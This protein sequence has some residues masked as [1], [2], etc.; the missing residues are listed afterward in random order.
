M[1]AGC[2]QQQILDASVPQPGRAPCCPFIS[3]CEEFREVS[4]CPSDTW[5][6]KKASW[7]QLP[8]R[9]LEPSEVSYN[10]ERCLEGRMG[11]LG[12]ASRSTRGFEAQKNRYNAAEA[13]CCC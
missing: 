11:E 1:G 3:M 6:D 7:I 2:S 9:V 12:T 8:L 4:R 13:S 10:I 5:T